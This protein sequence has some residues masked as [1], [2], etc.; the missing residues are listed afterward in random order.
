MSRM[1]S[2]NGA[3]R[4]S[5]RSKKSK[6]TRI[7]SLRDGMTH[8]PSVLKEGYLHKPSF[9]RFVSL[10]NKCVLYFCISAA[11][12]SRFVNDS[13]LIDIFF[14]S[15][16]GG[17]R[18]RWCVLRTYSSTEASLD[19]FVD[20]TKG[21]YKGT[22]RLDRD[23]EPVLM[24]RNE[25]TSSSQQKTSNKLQSSYLMIKVAKNVYHFTTESFNELK[26]WCALIRQV[27][28]NGQ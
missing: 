23:A 28:D 14:L 18:R 22:I 1:E 13:S 16:Q 4:K 25:E 7:L 9:F 10:Y 24:I 2:P 15:T 11:Q 6:S 8:R 21:R 27:I 19:I 3:N 12:P 20:D 17:K 5:V 26:E